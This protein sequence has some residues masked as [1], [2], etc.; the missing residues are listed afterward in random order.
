MKTLF[1]GSILIAVVLWISGCQTGA[2]NETVYVPEIVG[3]WWQVAG[4]PDLGEYTTET[5]QPVDFGIWQAADGT[6]QIWSCIRHTGCGKNTRLF[7]G[8]ETQN[9]TDTMWVPMGIQMMA[10]TSLGEVSGGLQAPHVIKKDGVYHMFYGGWDQICLATG[11]DGKKF[12]RYVNQ[13]GQPMLFRSASDQWINTRDAM[14][15]HSNDQYYCYYVAHK[16]SNDTSRLKAAIFCRTSDNLL[17]WGE[18][19]MVS[20]GGRVADLDYWYGGDSECPFVVQLGGK[21]V[22]FRNQRYIGKQIN[23]QYCSSDPLNFGV[24]NDEYEISQ[25]PVAAPEIIYYNKQ[26]YIAALNPGLDG[27]RIAKLKFNK[28]RIRPVIMK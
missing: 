24:D 11:T 6:W 3:D 14:V 22:L 17:H 27:I 16:P 7:H 21:Y 19:R 9:L 26:Y 4:N 10:D 13:D 12:E 2:K 8:W 23:T 20:A 25:L 18:E 1:K 5:Q 28:T 15:L